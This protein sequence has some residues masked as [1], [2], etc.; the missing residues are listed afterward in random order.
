MGVRGREGERNVPAMKNGYI[1]STGGLC[2]LAYTTHIE[3]LSVSE[4]AENGR[5]EGDNSL[6]MRPPNFLPR[7]P[8][9]FGLVIFFLGEGS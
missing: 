1:G 8:G 6:P 4:A 3:S 9:I 7:R 2:G 5:E